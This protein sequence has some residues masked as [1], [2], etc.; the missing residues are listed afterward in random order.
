MN[1]PEQILERLSRSKFRSGFKL[2]NK[3]LDYLS[4]KGIDTI[5][6]HAADFINT[7][8]AP[9][10]PHNDGKQTPFGKHPVFTAQ[11]ATGTC[12][13]GCL[14]KWHKI[15]KGSELIDTE[16]VYILSVIRKWLELQK[17]ND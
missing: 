2:Q 17:E 7:R 10:L 13:R 11:H 4:E 9:A 15:K 3:E 12:C 6:V 16:K 8:L 14:E 1:D 5:M